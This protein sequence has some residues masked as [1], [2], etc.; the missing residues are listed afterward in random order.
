MITQLTKTKALR[1]L[2]IFSLPII[3]GQIGLMLIGTGDMIIASKHSTETLAA[4]G[5]AVAIANPILMVALGLLFGISPLLAQKRGKGENIDKYLPSVF[6][7][8]LLIA[9]VFTGVT[10]LSTYIVPLLNYGPLLDKMI[11]EYL[12]ISS[13]SLFGICLYQGLREYLQSLEK[14]FAANLVAII[15][16]GVNLYLNYGLVFGEWG[17]P[18]LGVAGLAWASLGVRLFMGLIL[19]VLIS[20]RH[21]LIARIDWIFCREV[22]QLSIPIAMAVFFEVMAF[23]SV[24]LFVGHFGAIQTAANN[25][26]LT[27]GSLT[28]MIPLSI[29]SAAAV[30]VGHAYGEKSFQNV[31]TY[32]FVSFFISQFCMLFSAFMYFTIPEFL[33]QLF[34]TDT[35]VIFWGMQ[36]L[37][38]VGFFQFFDGAQVILA[39][40]LRGLSVT[41]PASLA[42][43]IGY[44]IIGIPLGYYFAFQCGMESKGMWTGLVISLAVVA[45]MLG[46]ILKKRLKTL[47]E[48]G[49]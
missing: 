15:G 30:K 18:H 2:M 10:L 32:I 21:K 26:A 7:L 41:R 16:V 24:T 44:W 42:I 5:L 22:L 33:L 6:L 34:T 35:Q 49:L 8:S 27:L 48:E 40:V 23:C 19:L 3:F 1:E 25:L 9:V 20:M 31:K 11:I 12:T 45:L 39:G 13:A 37:F 38:L 46:M 47:H 14:T 17:L 4:I 29:S 43:F 36:L 28:F